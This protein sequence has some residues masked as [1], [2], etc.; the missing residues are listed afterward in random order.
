MKAFLVLISLVVLVFIILDVYS[1]HKIPDRFSRQMVGAG[2]G[3]LLVAVI[4]TFIF[5]FFRKIAIPRAVFLTFFPFALYF[6]AT[7]HYF[8]NK[9]FKSFI[10]W[11]ILIV[12]KK[13]ASEEMALLINS[14][15]YLHS[16]IVGYLSDDPDAGSS[17]G[18]VFM[19]KN[20]NLARIA[21][22][23]N[24]DQIIVTYK[25]IDEELMKLLLGCMQKKVKV[26]DF[27]KVVEEIAGK[28]P[29]EYLDA[30]WFILEL[31]STVN[32]K[33]FWY[34]KRFTDIVLS[35]MSICIL[36]PF[37]PIIA[38]I[39]KLDSKGPVFYSQMRIGR[40]CKP[41]RVWKLRTM[42]A[43]ANKNNNVYWTTEKDSRITRVG[44]FLRKIRLDEVPQFFNILKGEMSFI[45]PRPETISN[46]EMLAKK[47]PYYTERHMVT[48]GITGWAQ[49]NYRYGNSVDDTKEKLKY[50][51]YYIKN[52][53][54]MLDI[55]IF[56]RTIRIVLTGKGAI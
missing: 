34:S 32:R 7:F 55:L 41:F 37:L 23:E 5:F 14:R 11:R 42:V 17:S 39:I 54:I 36:L 25:K 56:L 16:S 24:I 52:R 29:V 12:G 4:S 50:D 31:M 28:V 26:T 8:Y 47:I 2:M 46:V 49:I 13:K 18:L 51:F 53:G 35:L 3:L 10:S 45:G 38:L 21:E 6:I 19:G 1:V 27:K 9:L 33:Y 20:E 30:N 15:K 43:G 40:D 44:S 22:K 48:P